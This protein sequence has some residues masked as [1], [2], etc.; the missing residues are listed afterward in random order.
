MKAKRKTVMLVVRRV[1]VVAAFAVAGICYV[2]GSENEDVYMRKSVD[3]ADEEVGNQTKGEKDPENSADRANTGNTEN[4]GG[5]FGKLGNTEDRYLNNGDRSQ[6]AI[7]GD[8]R[9][10]NGEGSQTD[11]SGN[12]GAG[13]MT[14]GAH[15]TREALTTEN[16]R[17]NINT[18]GEEEL[19]TLKGI[20][21]AKA[22]KII[23]FR[24]GCGGFK[25][26]EEL[27]LVPGIKEATFSKIKDDITV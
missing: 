21:P 10:E 1:L 16:T 17:V 14:N 15:E 7:T 23:E 25:S 5:N 11:I 27:M 26:T 19:T 8:L 9:A 22:R 3:S 13:N 2:S 12:L 18:A 6:N 24:T 4:N 20:G